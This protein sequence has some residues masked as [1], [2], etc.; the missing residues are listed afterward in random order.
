MPTLEPTRHRTIAE[1]AEIFGK[2]RQLETLSAVH[3]GQLA[4]IATARGFT[5]GEQ[6]V[7]QGHRL[8]TL[9]LVVAGQVKM[10]RALPNGRR[11]LLSVFGPG[12]LFGTVD[13]LSDE[14]CNHSFVA[15]TDGECLAICRRALM[16]CL[17]QHSDLARGLLVALVPHFSECR[18]CVVELAAMRVEARL[19]RLLTRLGASVGEQRPGGLLVP[20][21]LRR[22]DLADMTG[23]TV[24]TCIRVMSRWR[25]EGL[26]ETVDEGFLITD[27]ELLESLSNA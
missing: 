21:T 12:Q 6:I 2:S 23:T 13:A 27:P 25:N 10:M 8:E 19:A 5:A 20:V 9:Y 22:Q 18:H 4:A 16:V 1:M 24:E 14:P 17:E 26:V 3:R 11:V 15:L 7:A